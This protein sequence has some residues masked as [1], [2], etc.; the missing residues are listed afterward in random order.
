[1]RFT[2]GAVLER[3]DAGSSSSTG[4]SS[5]TAEVRAAGTNTNDGRNATDLGN[6]T[7]ATTD[8]CGN[9]LNKKH[10][11]KSLFTE[12]NNNMHDLN[13]ES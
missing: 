6:T 7:N 4:M 8:M 1:M 3:I 2:V 9:S 13:I 11:I 10:Q 5:D 12:L